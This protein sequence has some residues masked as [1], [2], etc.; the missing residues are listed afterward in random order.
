[1]GG[2]GASRGNRALDLRGQARG[3][4]GS[5]GDAARDVAILSAQRV[6][7]REGALS[8]GYG[9]AFPGRGPRRLDGPR[10]LRRHARRGRGER[11]DLR[12]AATR[13]AAAHRCSY[14]SSGRNGGARAGGERRRGTT[15]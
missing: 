12:E 11:L 9:E 6:S 15:T 5:K 14:K 1:M 7:P 10:R 2:E 4:R 3:R 8:G 13:R